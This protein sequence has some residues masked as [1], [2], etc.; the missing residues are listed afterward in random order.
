MLLFVGIFLILKKSFDNGKKPTDHYDI[1]VNLWN[2]I[3]YYEHNDSYL[4]YTVK[5]VQCD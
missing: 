5:F 3:K 4:I 1:V 2:K